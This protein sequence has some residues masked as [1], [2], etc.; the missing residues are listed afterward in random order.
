MLALTFDKLVNL[1]SKICI[2]Y[3]PVRVHQSIYSP[4]PRSGKIHIVVD[5]DI[6]PFGGKDAFY[7]NE[8]EYYTDF[9]FKLVII[10]IQVDL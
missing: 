10:N 2:D 4:K 5:P 8:W 1:S 6:E 9:I 3:I 7:K